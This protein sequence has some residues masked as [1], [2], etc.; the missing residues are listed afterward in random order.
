MH[1]YLDCL[2][3][4]LSFYMEMSEKHPE[5]IPIMKTYMIT[6]ETIKP[7]SPSKYTRS[8]FIS[9]STAKSSGE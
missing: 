5:D 1:S 9:Q 2:S 7:L 4:R 3:E 6:P 8:K